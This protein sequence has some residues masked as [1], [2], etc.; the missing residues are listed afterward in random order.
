MTLGVSRVP[1]A[2]HPMLGESP[3]YSPCFSLTLVLWELP[4]PFS[5]HHPLQVKKDPKH[6]L[7]NN[8]PSICTSL[9]CRGLDSLLFPELSNLHQ[10]CLG[11]LLTFY[12][13][14]KGSHFM[15]L[16]LMFFV[17][18]PDRLCDKAFLC[19]Q[20]AQMRQDSIKICVILLWFG[21]NIIVCF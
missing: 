10:N 3:Q 11:V 8:N 1:Y 2:L 4:P 16:W 12:F 21:L 20:F 6:G 18:K 19:D 17:S 14:H 7:K 13:S 15:P 5:W 9:L